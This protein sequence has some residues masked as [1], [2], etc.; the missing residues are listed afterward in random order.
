MSPSAPFSPAHTTLSLFGVKPGHWRWG[1]AQMGTS[2]PALRKVK[3]LNFFKLLGSG[4]GRGFSLKPNWYRYGLMATWDSP[5]AAQDFLEGHP[6]LQEYREH[7]FE[8]YHLGLQPLQAHGL[9][10]GRNPFTTETYPSPDNAPIAVLTRATIRLTK[11]M[12]FWKH[13]PQASA[14]LD[15]AQGLLASIGLG[16]APL[17]RQATFSLWQNESDMKAYAYRTAS[18]R[19]V[20]TRTRTQGWY[21]EELFA[22]FTPISSHGTWNGVDPLGGLL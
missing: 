16:E 7:T 15:D 3:G 19:D 11:A 18:H 17:I 6:L 4:Q 20:I 9:W 22:R 10:S 13:V 8:Q 14:S 5:A 21:S 1:L 12:D 2:Q